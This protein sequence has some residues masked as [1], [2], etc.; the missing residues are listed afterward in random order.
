MHIALAE[1][2]LPGSKKENTGS[3]RKYYQPHLGQLMEDNNLDDQD[4]EASEESEKTLRE[5]D[6][7]SSEWIAESEY[8]KSNIS[9]EQSNEE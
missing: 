9:I 5:V 8:M 2:H 1:V 3:K 7:K 6:I 4:Q